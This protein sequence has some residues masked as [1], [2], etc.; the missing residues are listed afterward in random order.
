MYIRCG[1]P[2]MLL[3]YMIKEHITRQC[4]DALHILIYIMPWFLINIMK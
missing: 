3:E 1:I 4:T 2:V